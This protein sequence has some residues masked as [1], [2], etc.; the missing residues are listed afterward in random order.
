[1]NI[2]KNL[3]RN[4]I[5]KWDKIFCNVGC[6]SSMYLVCRSICW[7]SQ[8]IHA[9][10]KHSFDA[11]VEVGWWHVTTVVEYRQRS[12]N[13]VIHDTLIS[14]LSMP[15]SKVQLRSYDIIH[16]SFEA[17]ILTLFS[18]QIDLD[19]ICKAQSSQL[20]CSLYRIVIKGWSIKH[21]PIWVQLEQITKYLET[22]NGPW[23]QPNKPDEHFE[24]KSK[25]LRQITLHIN[26][27]KNTILQSTNF[28]TYFFLM[29]SDVH[30]LVHKSWW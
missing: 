24:K 29:I 1:M 21:L 5:Y 6:F 15:S 23:H 8:I 9:S 18:S 26:Q 17:E 3:L 4:Q 27:F 10:V 28:F 22:I 2:I 19:V 12:C 14:V 7:R 11:V 20:M 30:G 16:A 25:S 13:T